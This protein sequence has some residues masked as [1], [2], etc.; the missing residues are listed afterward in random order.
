MISGKLKELNRAVRKMTIYNK[1]TLFRHY[2]SI[3]LELV[4]CN[5]GMISDYMFLKVLQQGSSQDNIS[6]SKFV[7]LYLVSQAR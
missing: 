2:G 4:N 6:L 5:D 3:N 7:F 1:K